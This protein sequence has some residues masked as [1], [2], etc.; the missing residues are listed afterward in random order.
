[1]V[2]GRSVSRESRIARTRKKMREYE[3]EKGKGFMEDID[4][5]LCESAIAGDVV[6]LRELLGR[7]ADAKKNDSRALRE[8]SRYVHEDCIKELIP[9][10]D[11]SACFSE[12]LCLA[13][14][15]GSLNCVRMLLPFSSPKDNDSEALRWAVSNGWR[16]IVDT[17]ID[18]SDLS[19]GNFSIL[20]IASSKGR[21][22][23]LRSLMSKC[24]ASSCA[25]GLIFESAVNGHDECLSFL[26]DKYGDSVEV[27]NAFMMTIRNGHERCL[28]LFYEKVPEKFF[29]L[30]EK[31]HFLSESDIDFAKSIK[32]STLLKKKMECL[33]VPSRELGL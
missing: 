24:D 31:K 15:A 22:E 9:V 5:L 11:V 6:A 2:F 29:C 3:M 18:A 13:S 25:E 32:E 23:I 26:L 14:F 28:S 30:E 10:S 12:A 1:M 27:E 4:D 8:A 17:L 16:D 7:G 19:C 33:K 21:A 20:R